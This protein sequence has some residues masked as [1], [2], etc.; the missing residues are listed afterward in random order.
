MIPD[1][2]AAAMM[3]SPAPPAWK[4]LLAGAIRDPETLLDK[5]DLLDR[6][7]LLAAARQAA[8]RFPLRVPAGYLARM[9]KG[10]LDDPLLRQV[11]PLVEELEDKPGYVADPVGDL[12]AMASP[13]LLHKYHGRALLVATG[14]CAVH[15]R[16]C[17]RRE[18]PYGE[19]GAG[20][21]HWDRAF[22]LLKQDTSIEELILSGGDPL[23][24]TDPVLAELVRRAGA[25]P[26]IRRLRVHSR[27]PVV[28]PERVTPELCTLLEQTRLQVVHVIHANHAQEI[29]ESVASALMRLRRG[30]ALLLNQA[31]LLKGVNDSTPA[32]RELCETLTGVGVLPYYLHQLDPVR[33]AHHFQI[34]DRRAIGIVEQLRAALPGYMVP[35]LVR[36]IAGEPSKTPV[37]MR[38]ARPETRDVAAAVAETGKN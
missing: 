3:A 4:R 2:A 32:Q 34:S 33:G 24:L 5:L 6:P 30:N 15:C 23:T 27:L 22:T 8:R 1:S 38:P 7:G 11:L 25:V 16:Y 10:R 13:G 28:L 17:F 12:D 18:Y 37:E 29:D 36:E 21:R 9:R 26:H 31:V 35:R 19:A 14:A 20:S